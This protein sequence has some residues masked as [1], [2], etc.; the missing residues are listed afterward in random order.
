MPILLL[1][2]SFKRW[3]QIGNWPFPCRYFNPK[4]DRNSALAVG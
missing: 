4:N 3:R 1:A 2:L